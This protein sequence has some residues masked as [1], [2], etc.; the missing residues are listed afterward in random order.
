[1][2]ALAL[3]LAACGGDD[4]GTP[5]AQVKAPA[6]TTA[7]PTTTTVP[8]TTTTVPDY[9][10]YIATVKP[11]VTNI[12]VFTSPDQPA[13]SQ[14][15]PNPWLYDP[16]NPATGVPQMFLVKQQRADGWVAGAAPGATEREHRV[17]AGGRRDPHAE[18]VPHRGVARRAHHH[19]HQRRTT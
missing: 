5:K 10:S 15:F 8:P 2:L 13:P 1:M 4:G 3:V 18:P 12:G 16:G 11:T 6:T 17:G 9:I 7:P 19:R 14:T